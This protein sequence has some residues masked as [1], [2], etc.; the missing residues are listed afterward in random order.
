MHIGIYLQNSKL[1]ETKLILNVNSMLSFNQSKILNISF[2]RL[3]FTGKINY[4]NIKNNQKFINLSKPYTCS[5]DLVKPTA[6]Y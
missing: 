5:I 6:L 1:T 2:T 3:S 4:G